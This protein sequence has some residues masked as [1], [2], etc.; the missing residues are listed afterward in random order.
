MKVAII[1]FIC[2][3]LIFPTAKYI[4]SKTLWKD[5]TDCMVQYIN[6]HYPNGSVYYF[7]DIGWYHIDARG[8]ENPYM[9]KTWDVYG[10]DFSSQSFAVRL[11]NTPYCYIS[12]LFEKW[13]TNKQ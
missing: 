5:N 2:A 13:L 3:L 12:L 6:N 10:C 8:L 9:I 1:T 4:H 7:P 11:T